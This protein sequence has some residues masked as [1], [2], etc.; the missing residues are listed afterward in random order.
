M[1]KLI[2]ACALS[3]GGQAAAQP[4]GSRAR[5][6]AEVN[7]REMRRDREE[8]AR[9]VLAVYARCIVGRYGEQSRLAAF[10]AAPPGS[11][12][13]GRIGQQLASSACLESHGLRFH[14]ELFRGV[15]YQALYH[16]DFAAAPIPDFAGVPASDAL[17]ASDGESRGPESAILLRRYANCVTR[18]DP[19][20]VR[21]LVMSGTTEDD[22]AA[23]FVA[24]RDPLSACL[25][26]GEIRFSRT[27]LRGLLAESLY[28]LT[29]DA[30]SAPATA[31]A[32]N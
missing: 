25:G 17:P 4:A 21:A 27:M 3:T 14:E 31:T 20:A 7:E 28:R 29:E 11:R 16:R 15:I 9:R 24:L 1:L 32:A 26:D 12:L 13:A 2:A 5:D 18:A 23:A 22:E 30:L 19:R 10:L 6:P 8:E